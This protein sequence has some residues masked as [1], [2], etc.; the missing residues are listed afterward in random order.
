[1]REALFTSLARMNSPAA[2]VHILP[3]L[4]SDDANLRTGA[5]D[6]LRTMSLDSQSLLPSLLADAD[7]DVRV[8]SFELVRALPDETATSL[9]CELLRREPEPNVCAAALDVLAEVGNAEALP[10]LAACALK[11]HDTP[12]LAFAIRVT[13]DRIRAHSSHSR[14]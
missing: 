11:F 12:F 9:L 3:F 2:A 5:L 4:R 8:L 14:D 7:V 10:I 6:V 1:V 13:A